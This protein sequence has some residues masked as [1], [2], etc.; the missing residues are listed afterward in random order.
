MK[1][2]PKTFTVNDETVIN[3]EKTNWITRERQNEWESQQ[4]SEEDAVDETQNPAQVYPKGKK[5]ITSPE[6]EKLIRREERNINLK[7]TVRMVEVKRN[8]VKIQ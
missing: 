4:R 3:R 5:E 8:E 6:K 7:K 1:E 2:N